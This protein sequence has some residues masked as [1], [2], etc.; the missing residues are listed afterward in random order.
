MYYLILRTPPDVH[1]SEYIAHLIEHLELAAPRDARGYFDIQQYDGTSYSYYSTY[2]IDTIDRTKVDRFV[3]QLTSRVQSTYLT[4][5]KKRIR[6]EL[7]D[8]DYA[9]KVVEAIGKI[10]YGSSYR[11]ARP[12]RASIEEIQSYHREHYTRKNI[13]VY[14]KSD[15][16][17]TDIY[18]DEFYNI[19]R[20]EFHIGHDRNICL[21]TDLSS[22]SLFVYFLIEKLFDNYLDYLD[23]LSGKYWARYTIQ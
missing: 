5:E 14:T 11:Y 20:V 10:W 19:S 1:N 3:N 12:T 23:V 8:P 15:M 6:E 17:T 2:T 16:I 9:K 4:R 7:T 18:D 22:M 21:H 13:S